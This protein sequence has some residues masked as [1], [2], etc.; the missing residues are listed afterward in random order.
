[1]IRIAICDDDFQITEQI[2]QLLLLL[3]RKIS[4][5]IEVS[6]YYSGESFAKAIQDGC[7]FDI[8]LM[9][10]EM[11][12]MDGIRAGHVLRADV[13]N[14][15]VQIIYIS[16]YEQYHLQLFDVQPSGFIKKPFDQGS[17]QDKLIPAM[18]RVLRKL[19]QAKMNF[20]PIQKKGRELL[21]P[22]R[23]IL[24]LESK[25]RKVL[26]LTRS[27]QI[28]Y[29]STLNEEEQKLHIGCFIRI[30]Q[31]YIVNLYFVKEIN[32][33]KVTL[34]TGKELP[35]SEKKSASVKKKY[36]QFRGDLLA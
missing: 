21:I 26:L 23:D 25:A 12:G 1:M 18:Q 34:I 36:M 32:Y 6:I 20:L 14:D 11:K 3:Q 2:E 5:K 4:K 27:E 35:I 28:E 8:V 13:D 15:L 22:V 7:P 24:Y 19:Q 29:Y 10:I 9:D 30:H 33:K 17:F 31:S 16:N